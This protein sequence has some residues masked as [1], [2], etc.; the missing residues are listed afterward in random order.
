M[1]FAG[2][3]ENYAIIIHSITFPDSDDHEVSVEI[4]EDMKISCYKFWFDDM[5][6]CG[7]YYSGCS[8]EFIEKARQYIERIEGFI[9]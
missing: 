8:F 2:A 6:N 9:C 7:N 3:I 4:R 5:I 1:F